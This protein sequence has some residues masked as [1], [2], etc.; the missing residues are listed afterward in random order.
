MGRPVKRVTKGHELHKLLTSSVIAKE[1]A[2]ECFPFTVCS[3]TLSAADLLND[4]FY[5]QSELYIRYPSSPSDHCITHKWRNASKGLSNT[6]QG[7]AL[8]VIHIFS[9]GLG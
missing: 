2:R 3:P 1:R 9:R 5:E 4:Q 6:A 7:I 8:V